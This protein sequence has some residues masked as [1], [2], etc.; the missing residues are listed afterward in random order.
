MTWSAA[1]LARRAAPLLGFLLRRLGLLVLTVLI[2]S[3]LSFVMFTLIQGDVDG[4]V[5]LARELA[6]YLAATFVHAD[7]GGD[8]FGGA[9]FLRTR[10]ALDVVAEGVAPD[11]QRALIN[12]DVDLAQ[13]LVVEATVLIVVANFLADAAHAWLDPAC[14]EGRHSAPPT[15]YAAVAACSAQSR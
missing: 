9:T 3:S 12:R 15:R 1:S 7:L 8:V 4:R 2:V 14:A 10:G 5:G 6:A 11:I 13:A